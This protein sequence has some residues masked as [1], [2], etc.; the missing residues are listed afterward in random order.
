M[1]FVGFVHRIHGC[2][3]LSDAYSPTEYIIPDFFLHVKGFV[4][5]GAMDAAAADLQVLNDK[6]PLRPGIFLPFALA[7]RP[8]A[9]YNKDIYICLFCGG[10]YER[11]TPSRRTDPP[12]RGNQSKHRTH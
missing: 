2:V 12:H 7:I 6:N 5:F 3:P 4:K 11:S 10:L 1:L 9:W 8:A